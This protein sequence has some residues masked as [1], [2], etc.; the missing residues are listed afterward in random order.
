MSQYKQ[1][2]IFG[3]TNKGAQGDN[4]DSDLEEGDKGFTLAQ[5]PE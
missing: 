5:N 3:Y 2:S 4:S 1:K